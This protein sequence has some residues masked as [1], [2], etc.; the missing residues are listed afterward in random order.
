MSE[1][2]KLLD[3]L[4]LGFMHEKEMPTGGL[5]GQVMYVVS[6]DLKCKPDC[7]AC[8]A[9]RRLLALLEAGEK[10]AHSE[11]WPPL[12]ADSQAWDAAKTAAAGGV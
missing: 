10:L 11:L 7:R 4:L 6:S 8:E 5:P 3:R 9:K 1:F 2:E 12:K